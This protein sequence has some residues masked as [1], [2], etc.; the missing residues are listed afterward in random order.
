[1]RN[2]DPIWRVKARDEGRLR[3]TKEDDKTGRP[4]RLS[5][6]EAVQA[7]GK[8]AD[9]LASSELAGDRHLAAEIRGFVRQQPLVKEALK[10]QREV[11]PPQRP[12]P[13]MVR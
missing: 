10:R 7:W 5:R 12:D 11:A 6:S 3:E 4:A 9:A 8:I 1:M 2:F 13:E